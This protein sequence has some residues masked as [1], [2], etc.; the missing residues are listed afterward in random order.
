MVVNVESYRNGGLSRQRV[1]GRRQPKAG[2][3]EPK[4]RQLCKTM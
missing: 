4:Y 3:V 1:D 2:G